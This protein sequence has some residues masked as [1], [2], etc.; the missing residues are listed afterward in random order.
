MSVKN[1]NFK[2]LVTREVQ[3]KAGYP[4]L[5][6]KP[7]IHPWEGSQKKKS[8]EQKR[9][10]LYQ[11]DP[12]MIHQMT[13]VTTRRTRRIYQRRYSPGPKRVSGKFFMIKMDGLA[14]LRAVQCRLKPQSHPSPGRGVQC[15]E[16]GPPKLRDNHVANFAGE[17]NPTSYQNYANPKPLH[18][19][20]Q[21]LHGEKAMKGQMQ[22]ERETCRDK[23]SD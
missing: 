2:T 5:W 7:S 8:R 19:P 15:K 20:L 17:S 18:T 1:S 22:G 6:P 21:V 4:T 14:P 10:L 13:R 3:Q 23:C 9:L 12:T 11:N 16:M